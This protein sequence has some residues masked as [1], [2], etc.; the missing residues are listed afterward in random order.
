MPFV[1]GFIVGPTSKPFDVFFSLMSTK[2]DSSTEP[3]KS[4]L[5]PPQT[6]VPFVTFNSHTKKFIINE[7]A[8][9]ILSKTENKQIGIVSLVGKYRTRKSFLLNRV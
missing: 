3:S 6:A 1:Q 8:V 5:P 4:Q 9:K 7:E 2:N